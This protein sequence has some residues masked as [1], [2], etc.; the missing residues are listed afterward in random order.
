MIRTV[1]SLAIAC[2]VVALQPA[3]GDITGFGDGSG[4]TLNH[5]SSAPPSIS[6]GTL[7]LT[8][9]GVPFQSTSAFYDTPQSTGSFT[10]VFTYRAVGPADGFTFVIQNDPAGPAALGGAGSGLGY[11]AAPGYPSKIINSVGLEVNIYD[12]TGGPGTN[13]ATQGASDIFNYLSTK[14]VNFYTSDPIQF[15]IT[16]NATAQTLSETL[17]DTLLPAINYSHTFTN[18]DI[19]SQVHGSTAYVGF[20]GG[21]GGLTSTQTISDFRF[22]SA[23]P[24]PSSALLMALGLGV[25]VCRSFRR[26]THLAG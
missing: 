12:F 17:V 8:N 2:C 11:A 6:S 16:Y 7:T 14:P 24:E 26:T 5:I 18:I 9:L 1:A 3:R 10:A 4:Y 21:D 15:T 13:L 23:V 22:Q 20:T 19:A 25:V